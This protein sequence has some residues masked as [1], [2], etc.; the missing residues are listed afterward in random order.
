[1]KFLRYPDFEPR[2][3]P[4][5]RVHIDRLEKRGKFP[6]RVHLGPGTVAWLAHEVEAW[7]EARIAA[8]DKDTAASKPAETP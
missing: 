7:L 5:C 6:R 2:G 1:M 3:I 8:R 4:F